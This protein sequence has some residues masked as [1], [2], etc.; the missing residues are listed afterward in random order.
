MLRDSWERARQDVEDWFQAARTDPA[1]ARQILGILTHYARSREAYDLER[2]FMIGYGIPA[3][4]LPEP[5]DGRFTPANA[6][7]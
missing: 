1:A 6:V 2:D 5:E 3:A 7:R 4:Y